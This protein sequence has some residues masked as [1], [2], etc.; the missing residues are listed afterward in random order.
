MNADTERHII[1]SISKVKDT[2]NLK[3]EVVRESE[4]SYM[5]DPQ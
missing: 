1:I 3:S 4:L 5:R 2:E